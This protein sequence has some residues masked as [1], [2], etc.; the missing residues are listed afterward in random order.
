MRQKFSALALFV[1]FVLLT[2][3]T[4]AYAEEPGLADFPE[5][6]DSQSWVLPRDMT[7]AD[8]KPVPGVDWQNANVKP[9]RVL[10]GA[11][12]LVDF[13]DLEFIVSEKE[14]SEIAGNPQGV[15]NIPREELGKFWVDY[16]TKPQPLNNYRTI[17]EYWMENSYGKWKV[18]LDAFGVY[19]MDGN[20]FQYGLNE[21]NQQAYMPPGYSGKNLRTEAVSKSQK[22]IDASGVKYDFKFILHSGYAETG[23]WQEFG[24]MMFQ[25]ADAVPKEFGP[26]ADG[27]PNWAI[28]RYVPWTSWYAAKAIWSSA[29]GGVS[30]QGE[31]NGMATFAHEFGHIMT[32]GDNYNNPYG[33]PVSRTYAGSW[34]LMSSG[35][36]NG[37]GGS[38]TRWMI[39]AT[40]G[41]S[42]PPHHMLRNKIKQGFLSPN[43]YLSLDRD[44]LAETGPV[45][46]DILA[47]EVPTGSQFGRTGIYGINIGMV[48]KTPRNYLK[49]D[50]RADMQNGANWYNNYT[51][52]VVDRVGS[53]SFV[54]DSGVLMAK[55][56]NSESAP[57]IW[58]I[59]S[60]PEDIN[61]EDFKRPDGTTA[62][63]SKGG[64]EQLA[65]ALFKAGTGDGVVSE[66]KDEHNRLH[67]YI[68][69]K[70][71]DNAGALSYRVAVRHMDGSGP[72][73]RGVAV[74]NGSVDQAVPG[75]VAVYHFKVTNTGN[76]TD[77]FRLNAK[78]EAGW[79][80]KLQHNVIEVEA[81]KTID[82]PVYVKIPLDGKNGL[83]PAPSNLTFTSTSETD[84]EKSAS[85]IRRVGPGGSGK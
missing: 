81:G 22:D 12:I 60:H 7:W 40:Q 79:E 61:L 16:L 4:T 32:L 30:I 80:V 77:L 62:M 84:S 57:N 46:T 35:S 6:V 50:W 27:M 39:P 64:L 75:R 58:V 36:F 18:E 31:S 70:K 24:E 38:H 28:T 9:E 63:L 17:N 76:A 44:K 29:S 33:D 3:S 15:G 23:V 74:V 67:F 65:D 71:K 41:G 68:L 54:P 52:E 72:F 85:I 48:D 34:E 66:Y 11:L 2:V 14:G 59:D 37:P 83:S 25:N 55:T 78:S 53:D 42:V 56:R 51:L 43:Q 8:Y 10:K 5:P 26:P 1:C 49:N 82:V 20:E 45:F 19:R 13:P 69:D 73:T 47:R 21:F